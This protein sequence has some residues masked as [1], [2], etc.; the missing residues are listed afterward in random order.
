MLI[1]SSLLNPGSAT[2]RAT[3]WSCVPWVTWS[4]IGSLQKYLSSPAKHSLASSADKKNSPGCDE[5]VSQAAPKGSVLST[6]RSSRGC[7]GGQQNPRPTDDHGRGDGK[8][9]VRGG[10]WIIGLLRPRRSKLNPRDAWLRARAAQLLPISRGSEGPPEVR[11]FH[12][13]PP[14]GQ[15]LV[16]EKETIRML[17]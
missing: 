9:V 3:R 6:Q 2:I 15:W 16:P 14:E 5:I 7:H 8:I 13:K 17:C 10:G 1:P 11:R 12:D 4:W